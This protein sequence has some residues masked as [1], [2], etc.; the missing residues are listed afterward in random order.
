MFKRCFRQKKLN[1]HAYVTWPPSELLPAGLPGNHLP[2]LLLGSPWTLHRGFGGFGSLHRCHTCDE[3]DFD[4]GLLL[5]HHCH[6]LVRYVAEGGR[7]DLSPQVQMALLIGF[8]VWLLSVL[9]GRPRRC[10]VG[11]A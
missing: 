5:L 8:C 11:S 10:V 1:T 9:V 4:L 6:N 2:L 3:H 7:C